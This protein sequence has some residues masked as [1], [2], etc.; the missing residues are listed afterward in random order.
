MGG[1]IILV[2][3]SIDDLER[4]QTLITTREESEDLHGYCFD[5]HLQ[6]EREIMFFNP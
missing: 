2:L 6:G 5:I 1:D 4:R 3:N